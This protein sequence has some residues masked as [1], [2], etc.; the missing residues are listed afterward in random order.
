MAVY[1]AGTLGALPVKRGRK[2]PRHHWRDVD[3]MA[4]RYMATAMGYKPEALDISQ[5]AN[6]LY[7]H[8]TQFGLRVQRATLRKERAVR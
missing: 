6:Q 4:R 2:R 7:R 1:V 3:D 8:L 5:E